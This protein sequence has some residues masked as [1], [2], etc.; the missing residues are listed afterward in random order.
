MTR[1]ILVCFFAIYASVAQA[2]HT[3]VTVVQPAAVAKVT[4]TDDFSGGAQNPIGSPWVSGPGSY[5]DMVQTSG[6]KAEGTGSNSL[7]YINTA[8]AD[9]ADDHSA[10]VELD[11]PNACGPCVRV[12]TDGVC[13]L[14]YVSNSTSLGI[15]KQNSSGTR[16]LLGSSFTVT[17]MVAGD[18]VTLAASGTST[19]TLEVFVNGVSQ[20]TRTDS[21]SPISG[22]QPGM[23]SHGFTAFLT[24]SATDL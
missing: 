19:V 18:D 23:L 4:I 15:Y 2:G 11:N 16:T 22:G 1:A 10:T 14:I 9:F 3:V 7:A 8:S 5:I 21:S 12:Q 20:G 6:G 13:Y 17:T 24:F